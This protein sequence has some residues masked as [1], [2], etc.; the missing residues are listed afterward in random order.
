MKDA[1]VIPLGECAFIVR[2]SDKLD[3]E[4]NATVRALAD[5]IEV[6]ALSGVTDVVAANSSI[7]VHFQHPN[8]AEAVR[9]A[10][11]RLVSVGALP[12]SQVEPRLCEISVHYDG[13][14][15]PA[16][17]AATGLST[18]QIIDVHSG[19]EYQIFAIGF[20]PGF[21]YMGEVDERLSVPRRQ[22]PRTAVPAGSVAIANRQTAIYPFETPGGWNIIGTTSFRPFDISREPT[23]LFRVGDR[24]K[25][26]PA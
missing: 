7:G 1:Q 2:L 10:L 12:H 20:T 21:A 8:S 23:T 17:T 22:S 25:F 6:A 9:E 15:L 14:D 5:A 11:G 18:Q 16:I 26:V 24:V 4:V 19:Q 13:A 3:R